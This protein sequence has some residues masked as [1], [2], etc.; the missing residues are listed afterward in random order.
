MGKCKKNIHLYLT[1]ITLSIFCLIG[2]GNEKTTGEESY[3]SDKII[4]LRIEAD[5]WNTDIV[6]SP[7]ENVRIS[8]DGSI[9]NGEE[10]PS[11]ILQN[12]ILSVIQRDNNDNLPDQ[13]ALGKKGQITIY[14]PSDCVIPLA[15]ENGMGDIEIEGIFT[16]EFSLNNSSGYATISSITADNMKISSD[17]GDITLKE[18]S[19]DEIKIETSSGYVQ[20]DETIFSNTKVTT[21]SGETTIS[22][23]NQ[24]TNITIQS[25][26]GD[27]N[28]S[29]QTKPK[30]LDFSVTSGSKD[31]TAHF[32]KATYEKATS[33]HIQGIIGNGEYHLDIISEGGTVVVK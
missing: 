7:D 1:M 17:S 28:L 25:G 33:E 19:V 18:G 15:F 24:G 13:I 14:L 32:E 30:N 5:T 23:V 29:Y 9:S 8:F 22:K 31:V 26:S 2:C 10:K 27:I 20:I 16:K 4:A 6:I 11:A 21:K 12:G 3:P